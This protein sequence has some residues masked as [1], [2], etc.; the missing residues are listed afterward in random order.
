M[1]SSPQRQ[2]ERRPEPGA[3]QPSRAR[4]A[5]FAQAV[6]ALLC[7]ALLR[8][9]PA[10]RGFSL[11]AG[12]AAFGNLL[13]A[14]LLPVHVDRVRRI[15]LWVSWPMIPL[16]VACSLPAPPALLGLLTTSA[17]LGSL[18]PKFGSLRP[19]ARKLWLTLHIGFS[20]GWLGA[21][22]AMLV[23]AVVGATAADR[24]LRHH[25]YEIMHIF[26]LAIVI[27]LVL[28]SLGTG[29]VVSLGTRWG[30]VRYWWVLVKFVLA[31]SIPV[32]AGLQESFWVREAVEVTRADRAA[33]LAGTD[34]RLWVC[35]VVF[36][37]LLW[38]ATALS[39]YKP[40]GR[41]RW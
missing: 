5:L 41:T 26:D 19:R 33:E 37:L 28:L 22:M 24:E 40:W 35:F 7:L 13:L 2:R 34:L 20:V 16:F 31:L 6:V 25:A 12:V 17:A 38:T 15:A 8:G 23:L 21:A 9:D 10:N 18:R 3:L 29:L 27:P 11:A 14:V 39:A 30:L 36:T 32:F 4:L 1:V